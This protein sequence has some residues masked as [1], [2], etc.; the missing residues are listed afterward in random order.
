[1]AF[2]TEQI[3]PTAPRLK[4]ALIKNILKENMARIVI[5]GRNRLMMYDLYSLDKKYTSVVQHFSAKKIYLNDIAFFGLRKP[6]LI[7]TI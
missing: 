2:L 6:F 4:N 3:N 1:M 7:C 5:M